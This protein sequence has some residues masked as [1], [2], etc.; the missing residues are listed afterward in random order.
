M[1]WA[2]YRGESYFQSEFGI[3]IGLESHQIEFYQV[4]PDRPD[5]SCLA[6]HVFSFL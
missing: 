3:P 4:E 5:L 2:G 1:M 6:M